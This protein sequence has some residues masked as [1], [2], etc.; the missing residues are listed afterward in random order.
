MLGLKN[1]IL[2]SAPG[3][4]KG[5]FSQ[6]LVEKYGYIQICPGDIFRNE[7]KAQTELG[8]KIQ[9]L[10]DKGEYVDEQIVCTLIANGIQEALKQGKG[11]IIDGFPRSTHS[12]EFLHNFLRDNDLIKEVIFIQF[13]ASD[14]LCIKRISGRSVCT[15]C[16][17]VYNASSV[18]SKALNTC[19]DCKTSL[20][21][22]KADTT[23]I[24]QK[25]LDYF[26]DHVEP[27]IEQAK[28]HYETRFID[29]TLCSIQDLKAQYDS[30]IS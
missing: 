14:E 11:F 26:H 25:R 27:L 23:E 13:M 2:I 9:P 6:Y 15:E 1:F 16:H 19:D 17:K 12:F 10:V 18:R 20:T 24:A 3:S 28:T 5:T 7:I 30:L 22:R 29:T 21:I 4:G 8:K